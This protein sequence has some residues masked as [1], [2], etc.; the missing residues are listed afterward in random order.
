MYSSVSFGDPPGGKGQVTF[1]AG[2]VTYT[3]GSVTP[4]SPQMVSG[5]SHVCSLSIGGGL[6]S[7]YCWGSNRSGQ[8]GPRGPPLTSPTAVPVSP[9]PPGAEFNEL[10][11]GGDH[12]CGVASDG[13][14]YCWGDN[15]YGQLGTGAG[16]STSVPRAVGRYFP[17]LTSGAVAPPAA[18]GKAAL[19][20][21][22][23]NPDVGDAPNAGNLSSYLFYAEDVFRATTHVTEVDLTLQSDSTTFA[24]EFGLALYSYSTAS[25]TYTKLGETTGRRIFGGALGIP[26]GLARFVF[27]A[28]GLL[29]TVPAG[30][31][32]QPVVL[33]FTQRSGITLN[34]WANAIVN[35]GSEACPIGRDEAYSSIPI[36]LYTQ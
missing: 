35:A 32:V 3:S 36:Q 5:S 34:M 14:V 21:C 29:V 13:N 7:A 4:A 25:N 9:G 27:D 2:P 17:D 8:L 22:K 6:T 26:S 16:P 19:V 24:N 30:Q 28:P 12:T 20:D 18:N 11:A 31:T 23:I 1:T 33:Q 10:A 15:G